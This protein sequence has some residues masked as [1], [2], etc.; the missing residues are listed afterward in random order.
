MVYR[1]IVEKILESDSRTKCFK[2]FETISN[3]KFQNLQDP[4]NYDELENELEFLLE[5]RNAL[6]QDLRKSEEKLLMIDQIV[7]NVHYINLDKPT[8]EMVCGF[9][10]SIIKG[11]LNILEERIDIVKIDKNLENLEL[12]D[13]ITRLDNQDYKEKICQKVGKCW[14]H[15]GWQKLKTLELEIQI[16]ELVI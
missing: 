4:F 12:Q 9:D 11:D 13:E 14:K 3:S 15:S 16:E 5:S 8:N 2:S 7:D 6:K 10:Y 1:G